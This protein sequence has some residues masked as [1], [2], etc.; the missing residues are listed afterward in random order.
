MEVYGKR[1]ANLVREVGVYANGTLKSVW[2]ERFGKKCCLAL[3]VPSKNKEKFLYTM[4]LHMSFEEME[5]LVECLGKCVHNRSAVNYFELSKGTDWQGNPERLVLKASQY[6]GL[7]VVRMKSQRVPDEFIDDV[8]IDDPDPEPV[9][10]NQPTTTAA[11]VTW[12]ECFEQFHISKSDNWSKIQSISCAFCVDINHMLNV[13]DKSELPPTPTLP[14]IA[15]PFV[16]VQVH[17]PKLKT[18]KQGEKT[19]GKS[20]STGPKRKRPKNE[21]LFGEDETKD[22]VCFATKLLLCYMGKFGTDARETHNA[23][24]DEMKIAFDFNYWNLLVCED[25]INNVS[26]SLRAKAENR[27]DIIA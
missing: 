8:N 12:D 22:E 24:G 25:E 18:D 21:Q 13:D 11:D 16:Q 10:T 14:A 3:G 4:S 15:E 7:I 1:A 20:G 2:Y 23:Y 5:M 19:K 9:R 6:D 17:G 27:C 26:I